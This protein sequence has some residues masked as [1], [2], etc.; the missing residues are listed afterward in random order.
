MNDYREELIGKIQSSMEH[1][2]QNYSI[3]ELEE[4]EAKIDIIELPCK[5][6]K[7]ECQK[8]KY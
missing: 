7:C 4:L 8:N 6:V 3:E 2:Y 5:Q 1:K